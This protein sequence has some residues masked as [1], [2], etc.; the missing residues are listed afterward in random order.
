[1]RVTSPVQPLTYLVTPW[2]K[3]LLE[4]LTSSQVVKKFPSFYVTPRFITAF[5]SPPSFQFLSQIDTIH[6]PTIFPIP[7][8]DR[9]NPRPHTPIPEDQS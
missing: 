6:V 1:M 8:P 7:K 4:K 9:Y 3:V 2:T 5:T